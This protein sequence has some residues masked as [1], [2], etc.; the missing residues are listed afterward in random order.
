MSW[1]RLLIPGAVVTDVTAISPAALHKRGIAAVIIDL[2]NTLTRWND[3]RCPQEAAQWLAALR[4]AGI[5]CCIASNNG[6]G[7]VQA[8]CSGLPVTV[9]FVA[10][11]GKPALSAYAA[12]LRLLGTAPEETAAVGDQVFTDILGGNRAGLFTILVTPLSH[13][14]FPAT[15][16]LRVV[17]RIWLRRLRAAGAVSSL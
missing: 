14:E 13:H 9:P 5:A 16:I 1:S 2:D 17:E 15:R 8:F 7:R 3:Q 6:P 10:P 12:C 4:S 11:A